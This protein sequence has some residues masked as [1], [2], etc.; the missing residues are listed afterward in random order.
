MSYQLN[1]A[2]DAIQDPGKF[3]NAAGNT[4]CVEF[5]RQA[6]G[7]PRTS[8]WRKGVNVLLATPGTI[9]SGTAIAT[10]DDNGKYPTDTKG[11]HAAVYLGHGPG[12]IRVLDQWNRKG[13]VSE[14]TI[15]NKKL[16]THRVDSAKFYFVI[17]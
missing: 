15:F 14:R 13:R 12:G 9:P 5:V 17:E 6:C 8:T 11:K 10:F 16:A 3:A 7:A 2:L 1:P 4:E